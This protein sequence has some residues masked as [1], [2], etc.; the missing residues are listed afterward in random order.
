MRL[1]ELEV[2]IATYAG[3]NLR[4]PKTGLPGE[5]VSFIGSDLP[6]PKTE[7]DAAST[8]D[9]RKPIAKRYASR[10]E[11]LEKF[12]KS[13]D[14]LAADRFLLPEDIDALVKRGGEEWDWV[15]SQPISEK[16][17]PGRR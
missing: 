13:A 12:R 1:P 2:P 7:S 3:W 10:D 5:R 15:M 6:F 9:S 17:T 16:G 8:G 4:D 14:K 11:Y